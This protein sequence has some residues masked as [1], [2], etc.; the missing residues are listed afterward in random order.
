MQSIKDFFTSPFKA[1]GDWLVSGFTSGLSSFA[2]LI[3]NK[4]YWI[5]LSV[6]M[7][8]LFLYI[9]GQKQFKKYIALPALIY[10]LLQCLKV[11]L[12]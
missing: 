7:V 4:S 3:A 5:L 11:V 2:V 8:A 9:A 6:A 1:I 10:F 12:I